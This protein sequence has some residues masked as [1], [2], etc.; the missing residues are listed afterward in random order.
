[1]DTIIKSPSLTQVNF[2]VNNLWLDTLSRVVILNLIFVSNSEID[3]ATILGT[4][5]NNYKPSSVVKTIGMIKK[6]ETA[7]FDAEAFLINTNGT[8]QFTDI[9]SGSKIIYGAATVSYYV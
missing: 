4:V 3:R 5:P 8:I 6:T 9:I 1:M 2:Y 7:N